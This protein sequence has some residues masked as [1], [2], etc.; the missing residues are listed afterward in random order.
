MYQP[1]TYGIA[2]TL[3]LISMVCWGSWPVTMKF[4]RGWRFELYYWDFVFGVVLTSLLLG[5]TLGSSIPGPSSFVS[6][7]RQADASHILWAFLAGIIFD[8]A[9]VLL[10]A[11]IECAGLS[12]AFPLGVG[13]ALVEGVLLNYILAPKGDPILLF[14]GV[15]L[16]TI[17][18]VFDA[19]AYRIREATQPKATARGIG[20]SLAAGILLGLFYPLATKSFS[21]VNA[22]GPFT[23]VFVSSIGALFC[24]IPVNYYLMRRPIGGG[25]PL[26][27]K[28]YFDGRMSFHLL[29]LLGGVV[30]CLGTV[31]SLVAANAHI[32]GPAVSYAI[33]QG[34]TMISALWGVFIWR[35]FAGAPA[36]ARTQLGWMFLLFVTGLAAVALA[37]IASAASLGIG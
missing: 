25:P 22:L 32:V 8:M 9:N 19:R 6:N 34:C 29:G 26:T 21:G 31:L 16:V 14:G 28:S 35:E 12:V 1:T 7:L 17:A 5:M 20:I 11:A 23:L 24:N 15:I 13:L 3:M 27:I 37:P 30:W 4:A 36:R 18:I 10:V 2:L 33:G